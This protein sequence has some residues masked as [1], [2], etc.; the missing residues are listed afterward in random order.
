MARRSCARSVNAP[1]A[2]SLNTFFGSGLCQRG[3]LCRRALAGGE[4]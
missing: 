1:L 4:Y 3:D 2:V